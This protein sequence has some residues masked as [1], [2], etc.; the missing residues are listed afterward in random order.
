MHNQ[1][2]RWHFFGLRST[3][4]FGLMLNSLD[5]GQK[6]ARNKE[7]HRKKRGNSEPTKGAGGGKRERHRQEGKARP[8]S[9][10][11]SFLS[12]TYSVRG[13]WMRKRKSV[14]A[15]SCLLILCILRIIPSNKYHFLAHVCHGLL[16]G[17]PV[18]ISGPLAPSRAHRA[19]PCCVSCA[20]ASWGLNWQLILHTLCM[21]LSQNVYKRRTLRAV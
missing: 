2:S 20:P 15:L 5:P 19:S 12:V 6:S 21:K 9:L 7:R 16:G 3:S 18:A 17:R 8:S 11:L 13:G 14:T 4:I 10:L 1:S